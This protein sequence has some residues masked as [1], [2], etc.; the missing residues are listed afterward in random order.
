[1]LLI[2]FLIA[3]F[4]FINRDNAEVLPANLIGDFYANL[5]TELASIAITILLIDGINE[6]RQNRQLKEQLKRDL[7]SRVTDFAVR[8]VDELREHQW[9]DEIFDEVKSDLQRVK[10]SDAKL[11]KVNLNNANLK[12]A[13]L[14]NAVLKNAFLN[15]A[16]LSGAIMNECD[17]TKSVLIR[18]KMNRTTLNKAILIQATL[19]HSDLVNVDLTSAD[20]T[21]ANV[22]KCDLTEA[23]LTNAILNNA[24]LFK[25][26]LIQAN[27]R[28]AFLRNAELQSANLWGADLWKADLNGAK[29][30]EAFLIEANLTNT[31]LN[32]ADLSKADLNNAILTN[33]ELYEANLTEVENLTLMQLSMVKALDG[34]TMPDGTE[35]KD[36]INEV[37][38]EQKAVIRLRRRIKA[39]VKNKNFQANKTYAQIRSEI[40]IKK[41]LENYTR[42]ELI[43]VHKILNSQQE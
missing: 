38:L 25:A 4:G 5:S 6:W 35:Y 34:A 15:G 23:K 16:D 11:S 39:F 26:E 21:N 40:S 1:M 7:L 8:A 2:A 22:N 31:F 32:H 10:L 27:L 20:L 18:A 9:L 37:P 17:L 3:I 42:R 43:L 30:M 19:D 36:W 13:I 24:K 41:S 12:S 14:E 28:E 33:A 29:L